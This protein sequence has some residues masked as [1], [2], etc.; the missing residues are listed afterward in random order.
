MPEELTFLNGEIVPA[1]EALISVSD[2]SV[3]YGDSD[4]PI[5]SLSRSCDEAR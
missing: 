3:L 2:R 1:H 4:Q 5:H